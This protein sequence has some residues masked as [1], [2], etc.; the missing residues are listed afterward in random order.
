M[1]IKK[2]A[3]A[4]LSMGISFSLLAP[5]LVSA[6]EEV[7][8]NEA[9]S[10]SAISTNALPNWPQGPD[11]TS[12]AAVIMEDSTNAILYAKNMDQ[13]LDP[14]STVKVMTALLALET[15]NLQDEIT[16]TAT[17]LAGA[18]DG[19]A[20]IA[21]QMGEVFTL[22][23]CLYGIMV[24]SANDLCLQVAEYAGG[25]VENFVDMMNTRAAELGCT[26]TVFSNPT[27]MADENQITTAHDMA[28]IMKAAI[29]KEEFQKIASAESYTIPAT[30]MSGERTM[31]SKFS[32]L[33]HE[34]PSYYQGV[35]GGKQGYTTASLSTL[36]CAAK[37]NDITLISVV[38]QGGAEQTIPESNTLLDYAFEN[39]HFITP[40][41]NDFSILSGGSILLPSTISEDMLSIEESDVNGETI[42]QYSYEGIL[43]GSAVVIP[44]TETDTSL[45][46]NHEKH[47][48]TARQFS[49]T[50]SIIPYIVILVIFLGLLALIIRALMK[51]KKF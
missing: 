40:G 32:M 36:I 13:P 7:P 43:L 46:E 17:G 2:I 22:E 5:S 31:T 20:H 28:L 34:S 16:M 4:L 21:A 35:L 19:G 27:G 44:E 18:T 48:E 39:F 51:I 3:A 26:N 11:I 8:A 9:S 15:C 29:D 23:Q 24:A 30:N 1:K 10:T 49:E 45:I 33:N 14:G 41:E 47:M 25:S 12:T 6:S 38:L 42:R 50:K 37:R